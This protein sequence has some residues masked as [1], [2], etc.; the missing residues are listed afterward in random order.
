MV[1]KHKDLDIQISTPY[2][3]QFV[4]GHLE[5]AVSTDNDGLPARLR[6]LDANRGGEGVAHG[7]QAAASQQS[8][9]L[10]GKIL[11]GKDLSLI[12]I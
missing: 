8:A 11:T 4:H 2:G 3:G 6:H 7:P 10:L 1:L 12:H 9:V 5:R